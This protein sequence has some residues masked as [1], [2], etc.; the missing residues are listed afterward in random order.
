MAGE[1]TLHDVPLAAVCENAVVA[2]YPD[3]AHYEG[4]VDERTGES[5]PE[6]KVKKARG[7]ELAKMDEHDV[8]RDISWS[9][10]RRLGLK[11]VKSRWVDGWKP[12]P[13]DPQGVRSR[14]VA[15]E[16]NTGP[17]DDGLQRNA[18]ADGSQA[19]RIPSSYATE[20]SEVP[21]PS[22]CKIRRLSGVLPRQVKWTDR[23]H[24]TERISVLGK[25][26]LVPEQVAP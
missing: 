11:I 14:C 17:R 15:M 10:A 9:E 26:P 7:R 16:I 2:G 4:A 6:E 5:L 18:S 3:W 24:S 12:L 8:K 23:G 19:H 22:A 13:D 20:G 21:T 1:T 25:W